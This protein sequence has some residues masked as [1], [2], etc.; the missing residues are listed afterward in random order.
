M[1]RV[2]DHESNMGKKYGKLTAIEYFKPL[3]SGTKYMCACECGKLAVV[4]YQKLKSGHTKSCGCM[5][6]KNRYDKNCTRLYRIWVDMRARCTNKNY[7]NYHRYGERGIK[8]CDEW[9]ESFE[10][11]KFW[12][13]R[14]GYSDSL[15]IDRIDNDKGYEP[16][17]CRWATKKE[18]ANNRVTNIKLEYDGRKLSITE[19]SRIVGIIPKTIKERLNRGWSVE[20]ALTKPINEKCINNRKRGI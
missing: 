12:A 9:N 18:Q 2:V 17:N 7:K 13:E 6:F 1:V 8:L 19:W 11:F 20:D 10:N 5:K 16:T 15:T 4:D 14:N 3:K